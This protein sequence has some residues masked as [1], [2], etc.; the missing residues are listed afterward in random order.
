MSSLTLKL[1]SQYLLL[2]RSKST[3]VKVREGTCC[4][5]RFCTANCHEG[6]E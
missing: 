4:G 2:F 1:S 6:E 5:D 3:Q